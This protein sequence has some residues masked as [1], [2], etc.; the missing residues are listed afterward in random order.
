MTTYLN[1]DASNN[2]SSTNR[3]PWQIWITVVIMG[4]AGIGNVFHVWREPVALLWVAA[5]ILIITGLLLR[6]RAIFILS[7]ILL[8][9]HVG[10]FAFAAPVAAL[11]NLLLLVL[12]GSAIRFYFPARQG[13]LLNATRFDTVH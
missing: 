9:F 7:V 11:I 8:S 1:A 12:M 13:E 10:V 5:K 2:N 4:L 3:I 6:W